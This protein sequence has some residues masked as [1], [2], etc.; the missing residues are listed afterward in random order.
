VING[1]LRII[2]LFFSHHTSRWHPHSN[3]VNTRFVFH[4][5]YTCVYYYYYY[6]YYARICFHLGTCGGVLRQMMNEFSSSTVAAVVVAVVSRITRTL[7]IFYRPSFF[8]NV[9][10]RDTL[11]EKGM[12]K[13][14]WRRGRKRKQR[15]GRHSGGTFDGGV[16]SR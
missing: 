16:E 1:S 15:R 10:R 14:W 9:Y 12:Y 6:Y 3:H 7:Y 13:R 11:L 5:H 4:N 8:L 2:F